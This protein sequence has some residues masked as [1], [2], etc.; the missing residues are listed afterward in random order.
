MTSVVSENQIDEEID[1]PFPGEVINEQSKRPESPSY[2][3][4]QRYCLLIQDL[5]N[6]Q[7]YFP[8]D[9]STFRFTPGTLYF[10]K[11]RIYENKCIVC[12]NKL[13]EPSAY[14]LYK[15]ENDKLPPGQIDFYVGLLQCEGKHMIHK[16]CFEEL[17]EKKCPLCRDYVL[18][19]G[20]LIDTAFTQFE[21]DKNK[22][23][24]QKK[25]LEEDLRQ[26][27]NCE[28][29]LLSARIEVINAIEKDDAIANATEELGK[30]LEEFKKKYEK[31]LYYAGL[32]KIRELRLLLTKDSDESVKKKL[33]FVNIIV[34]FI[35]R[36]DSFMKSNFSQ[37]LSDMDWLKMRVNMKVD[38]LQKEKDAKKMD[39]LK[40]V[41]V[42]HQ[43][44]NSCKGSCFPRHCS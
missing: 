31:E 6:K 17:P 9:K 4:Q 18:T 10:E 5:Y 44:G 32:V 21:T 23:F 40:R 25:Q 24:E 38:I 43:N 20:P 41:E 7:S 14:G 1:L 3:E 35:Y 26:L 29:E 36:L 34:P 28:Q 13:T 16:A 22:I 27:Q 11:S 37:N 8:V 30:K 33:F 2:E 15:G 19:L 12:L 42:L 39:T